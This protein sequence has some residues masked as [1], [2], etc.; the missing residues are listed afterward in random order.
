MSYDWLLVMAPAVNEQTQWREE[1]R[2][3]K[4]KHNNCLKAIQGILGEVDCI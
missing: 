2:R 4:Q 1:N 3:D